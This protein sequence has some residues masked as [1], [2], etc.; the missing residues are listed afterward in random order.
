MNKSTRQISLA[1]MSLLI[2]ADVL[3]FA[4]AGAVLPA[5]QKD[6]PARLISATHGVDD[7]LITA[8]LKNNSSKTIVAYRIGWV[9]VIDSH[10]KFHQGESWDVSAGIAPG[11]I[12]NIPPQNVKPNARSKFT[13]I[14]VAELKFSDGT[15]WKADRNEFGR[16]S[17]LKRALK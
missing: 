5:E 4:S 9:Y 14:F 7:W 16:F 1:L 13:E 12:Y 15:R 8:L 6:A 3:L 2:V 11:S 10:R 17:E